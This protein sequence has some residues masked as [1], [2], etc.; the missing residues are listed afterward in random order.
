MPVVS[1]KLRI[2]V[3]FGPTPPVVSGGGGGVTVCPSDG[4]KGMKKQDWSE[5]YTID[6]E[7]YGGG[8]LGYCGPGKEKQTA[9]QPG[10]VRC[11]EYLLSGEVNP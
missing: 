9:Q 6:M 4:D 11:H 1:S 7:L 5:Q 10:A 8:I 2:V 3:W